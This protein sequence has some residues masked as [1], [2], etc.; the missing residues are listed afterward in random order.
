ME[1]LTQA[2]REAEYA[3]LSEE[4]L[5]DRVQKTLETAQWAEKQGQTDL[6]SLCLSR[7]SAM[8]AVVSSGDATEVLD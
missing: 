8:D 1:E 7:L 6:R 5:T 2:E 4:Q 3:E